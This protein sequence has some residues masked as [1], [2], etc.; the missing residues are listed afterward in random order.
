MGNI[1]FVFEDDFIKYK[2]MF[3]RYCPP[4][5]NVKKG[6]D[7]CRQ[8]YT[9]DWMYYLA[10]GIAK[11]YMTNYDGNDRIIDFMKKN[12][13]IGMDCVIPT[14]KSVVSISCV[15][16]IH[17][18]PFNADILKKMLEEDPEFA[19]DLVLYYGKVLRQVTYH[20]G[21]LGISNLTARFANFLY[22][23]TDTPEYREKGR[24]SMTQEEIAASINISRAQVAK[25]C[26][27]MRG[28]GIIETGN[29]SIVI[30]DLGKLR[31]YCHL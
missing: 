16:D 29:R 24:I 13:L 10:D 5:L 20:S 21:N 22:L 27:Q 2:N 3:E 1:S 8:C 17:V 7:L 4:P 28:E 26:G 11:V 15:T 25:M 30:K 31:N 9:S 18:L 6:T 19:Y 23:F 12:T 14:L